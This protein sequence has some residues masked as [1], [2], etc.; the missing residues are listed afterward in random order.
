M[1][2][3]AS[4]P[5]LADPDALVRAMAKAHRRL[6]EDLRAR[7]ADPRVEPSL[8][9]AHA[10]DRASSRTGEPFESYRDAFCDQVAASWVLCTVFARTLED[11][12]Y[13]PHRLA[14]PGA[15]DR[16]S[17]FRAQFK[18]LGER[19]YLLHIFDAS[20]QLPGGR[21][22]FGPGHAPLWRLGPTSRALGDLLDELR[23]MA[24]GKLRFSF[25]RP[26]GEEEHDGASTRYL[27]D[28]YQNLNEDVR[29]R[30]ALLQTPE[31]VERFI[32]DNTLD[33]AIRERG[34]A[35]TVLDPACGSGHLLLGAY[36]RLF[37]ARRRVEPGMSYEESARKALGQ[38]HGIDL[39]PYAAAVARFRLL[40]SYLDKARI[41]RLE[42]VPTELGIKVYVGDALLAGL[43]ELQATFGDVLAQQ[44]QDIKQAGFERGAFSFFDPEADRLLG[45]T[46]FDVIVANPPYISEKDATKREL[47]R[48]RYTAA[49]GKYALSVPFAERIFQ[50]GN[51]GAYTGQIT[52]NSFMKRDFGKALIAEV[53]PKVDLAEVIDTSGA[54]I[55]G[56]GTP[57]VILFGRARRPMASQVRV[58]MGSRGEPTTPEMPA[59]GKVWSSIVAHHGDVGYQ[60]EYISVADVDREKLARHPWSFGGGGALELKELLEERAEKRLGEVVAAAGVMAVTGEDDLYTAHDGGVL[61]RWGIEPCAI[62][63]F[64][65]GDGVRD[66]T[67]Q[68]KACVFSYEP[69]GRYRLEPSVERH[70]W[71]FRANRRSG[72]YFGKTI[73][74][75]GFHWTEYAVLVKDKLRSPSSIVFAFVATHNHFVLDRGG[76]VFNR[77][78]PIIKLPEGATEEEHLALLGY[79]NSSAA[80]FWMK[81][82]CFDRGNRGEG[83]GTTAEE[84]ERFFEFTSGTLGSAPLPAVALQPNSVLASFARKLSEFG[85]RWVSGCLDERAL[86]VCLS[87]QPEALSRWIDEFALRRQST[88]RCI[89]GMQEELDWQVYAALGLCSP[90][91]T[92]GDGTPRSP[93]ERVS[94]V[95]FA[96]RI[97]KE[98]GSRRYFQLCRLPE[99]EIVAN[100]ALSTLD[101]RRL[102]A[103]EKSPWLKLLEQPAFKR[104]YRES[105]RPVDVRD[106]CES[107]LLERAE[108]ALH[109]R[110]DPRPLPVRALAHTLHQDSKVR[111]V[112]E[113]LTGSS[114]YDLEAVLGD[115]LA[116]EAVVAA[117]CQRYTESG[118]EKRALWE[119]TWDLQR[120]ED[121]GEKV[122]IDV[123][124]KYDQK[125][126]ENAAT[127]WRLRGKL[128]VPKERFI[129]YPTATPPPGA[130]GKAG[131]VY[132][133]AGWT[134]LEQL[135]AAIELWQEEIGLHGHELIPRATRQ[136]REE[137]LGA[138]VA[139]TDEKLLRDAAVRDKLMPLLQTM[140]D[141]LPWVRRWH[142]EDGE[143]A[144]AFDAYVSEQAR[145]LEV[146]VDDARAYRRPARS[147]GRGRKAAGNAPKAAASG[148]EQ[149]SLEL[150]P[151]GR[152][153]KN[154]EASFDAAVDA[155][156]ALDQGSGVAP[157]AL[158][159]RLGLSAAALKKTIDALVESGRLVERKK[160]PRLVS[161]GEGEA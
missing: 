41:P 95:L 50:L 5:P 136:A 109:D 69:N 92:A 56:H 127:V 89:R 54:Y 98:V 145:R 122:S 113:V 36:D 39:N 73:E 46:R 13:L 105:F 106:A 29:K 123:P 44:G 146:S 132:G 126:F 93:G 75:R 17:Q 25:G 74:Q 47:V 99:P 119:K 150:P 100:Q 159:E 102:D 63:L 10:A 90:D 6:A 110:P 138:A 76:K 116:K 149:L 86:D 130:T 8:R 112:A 32:L 104:T 24:G 161:V 129:A 128:D 158:G 22:V 160:R 154:G 111:A 35:V 64:V 51:D 49:A 40:L 57:T 34:I 18:Y 19:D 83:G 131:L 37:E 59:E 142:D 94:D 148:D 120:R 155:V 79:L 48:A 26:E 157:A 91:L 20:S 42:N 82:E 151:A 97:I 11:R 38:V 153:K 7:A 14:G 85:E 27:G 2:T 53:L 88:E 31:F 78:A 147:G 121:A 12:G 15:S 87:T 30:Y 152:G 143:T 107:W 124:R 3:P 117:K 135:Q 137:E 45:K 43:R 114:N 21:E 4:L 77:T 108:A 66:W 71:P 101:L 96:R 62:R 139:A 115:L 103:I 52:S 140:A 67:C 70:L 1:N 61:R 134:H 144:D 156:R 60:D 72:I 28:L 68:D 55:P 16:L 58:T 65:E 9:D 81:Q 133:W 118:L 23:A 125:D 33:P 80:C 84:W 141:L